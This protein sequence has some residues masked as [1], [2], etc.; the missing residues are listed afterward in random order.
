MRKQ[1]TLCSPIKASGIGLHTGR[2][3]EIELNPAKE[4]SGIV[5]YREDKDVE[6]QLS[7]KSVVDTQLATTIGK[8]GVVIKTVE[9]LLSTLFALR[10]DNIFIKL[11]GDEIPIMDGSSAPW[12]YL[13]KTAGI[14]EQEAYK[15]TIIVKKPVKIKEN[16][17]FA[18]LIPSNQF[19][20]SYSISFSNTFI[21]KQRMDLPI[22]ENTFIKEI[23]KA[24]TFGF[25]KDI[26]YLQSHNLALGGSLDNAVVVDEYGIVNEDPL[27][28]ED[29]FV[30]HKILDA[31]G[32]LSILGLDMKGK[33]I[34][35]K[36]GHNLNNK[37]LRKL[38]SDKSAYEIAI[39]PT[40]EKKAESLAW[41]C[42]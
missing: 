33:Y 37:L 28:Y 16:G 18:A 42:V 17:K 29:E 35:Y 27:R 3:V 25:L 7:E 15:K 20:I 11:K 9:H 39:N 22:N 8:D 31:I 40:R 14:V 32:D 21:G 26:E 24:R 36:S 6:I 5:F 30:R 19:E 2:K 4:N 13:I 38:I 1:R 34:A 12:V 41:G 10:I 23:S